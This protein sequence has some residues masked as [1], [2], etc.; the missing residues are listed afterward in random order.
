MEL[1]QG[2]KFVS[3]VQRRLKPLADREGKTLEE[4]QEE[5]LAL[6]HSGKR[7]P[8]TVRMLRW[9]MR[10]HKCLSWW[11]WLRLGGKVEQP[12]DI[13]TSFESLMSLHGQQVLQDG[14][15]NADPHPG[16]VMLLEDG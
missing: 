16:N 11:S 5:Q 12:V 8:E 14:C 2:E 6:L 15:F 10:L 13:A 4:Y 9:K 3:A 1:L 7:K